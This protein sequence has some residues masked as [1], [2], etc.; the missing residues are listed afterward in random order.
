M[1]HELENPITHLDCFFPG[2]PLGECQSFLNRLTT[3]K[4][5]VMARLA[6]EG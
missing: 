2:G 4:M 6:N 3:A 5:R 1:R